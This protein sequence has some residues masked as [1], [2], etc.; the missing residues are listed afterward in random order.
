MMNQMLTKRTFFAIAL[1][2]ALAVLP[3]A[4]ASAAK[5]P[6]PIKILVSNDDGVRADGINALVNALRKEAKVTVTVIAPATNVSG[7]GSKTTPGVLTASP[8]TTLG[9][10]AATAVNGYPAD[11]V[12]YALDKVLTGKK[13]PDLVMAGINFGANLGPFVPIS[14]TVGAARAG[15]ARGIPAIAISQGLG[16]PIGWSAGVKQAIAW[17]RANRG[18]LKKGPVWNLNIPTCSK[19][20]VR[21]TVTLKTVSA[22]FYSFDPFGTV[23]CSVMTKTLTNDVTAFYSGFA[24]LVNIGRG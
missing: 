9:G 3:A 13:K 24:P 18:S 23:D 17:F 8:T 22:G 1:I 15:A 2:S 19:G 10:V 16:N 21:G 5:A 11:S 12:N 20:A 7:T 4:S 14:G 6:A